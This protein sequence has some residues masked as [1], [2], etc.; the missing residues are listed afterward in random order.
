MTLRILT[1]SASVLLAGTAFAGS[2]SK[3]ESM[4][5]ETADARAV[6]MKQ[7]GKNIGILGSMARGTADYDA[8]AAVAAA[9]ALL[10]AAKVPPSKLWVAGTGN[11]DVPMS[12]AKPA[13]FTDSFEVET[14]HVDLIAASEA[15]V[16]AAGTG[17]DGVRANIGA[18]G[19]VCGDCH[20]A[21]RLP[22]DE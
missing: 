20:K 15:M 21:Y 16:A 10:E 19:G 7:M 12:R 22:K 5:N 17:L 2:H 18:I 1:L 11:P 9:E 3:P 13:I 6:V 4:G 8:D 14:L